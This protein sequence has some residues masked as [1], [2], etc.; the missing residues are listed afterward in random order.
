[1]VPA[2]DSFRVNLER[3]QIN[4]TRARDRPAL[5]APASHPCTVEQTYAQLKFIESS[6]RL[7]YLIEGHKH[8][9]A[10]F[11]YYCVPAEYELLTLGS[12]SRNW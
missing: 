3:T 7:Q 6:S 1:M 5:L 4:R 9:G 8:S 2:I 10:G 11:P 12:A